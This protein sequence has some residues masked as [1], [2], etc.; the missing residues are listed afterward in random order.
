MRFI[1]AGSLAACCAATALSAQKTDTLTLRNGDR[2]IG[3][4]KTLDQGALTLKTDDAG[5]LTIKWDKVD[6]LISPR[7]FEVEDQAGRHYYGALQPSNADGRVVVAVTSFIDTLDI[8]NVVRIYPIGRGFWARVDGKLNASLSF[9]RANKLRDFGIDFDAK[10]RTQL[11]L[12][13]LVTSTY[14]QSQESNTNTS[15]NSVALSQL[16][17]LQHRWLV[18]AA[19]QLEQNEELDLAL[20]GLIGAGGG[21]FLHQSNRSEVRVISGLAYSNER[22]VGS[23]ATS[24][25]EM[26][27]TGQ[28]SYFRR[29]YPRANVQT[30]FTVYPSITDFGRVRTDLN[31]SLTY[32]FIRDF[33]TGLTLFD[34]FD[35][36]PSSTAA[37]KHDY[38]LSFTTGWLF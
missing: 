35:S 33:N 20:R 30:T 29:D 26:L 13:E 18:T 28:A 14:F 38:G 6:R 25:L 12:T 19:G 17:F 8:L 32:E 16:R 9:Q 37:A 15:R 10:H 4:I 22:F 27:V 3:E 21:R 34:K 31:A 36:R 23:S 2:I 7:Y 24:N 1:A 11:R 5:T